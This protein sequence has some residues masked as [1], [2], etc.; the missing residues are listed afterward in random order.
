MTLDDR[1][2]AGLLDRIE[3]RSLGACPMCLFGA[4]W[5]M[6]EEKPPRAVAGA[7]TTSANW[8]FGEMEDSLRVEL[9]RLRWRGV[10]GA[11]AAVADLDERGWRS[12]VVRRIVERLAGDMAIEMAERGAGVHEFPLVPDDP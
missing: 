8:T 5:A 2:I 1:T 11:E 10:E 3:L 6:H 12:R 9:A 4:A 7:V